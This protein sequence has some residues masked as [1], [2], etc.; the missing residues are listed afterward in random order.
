M[1]IYFKSFS[2][3]YK[4]YTK[5]QKERLILVSTQYLLKAGIV[6]QLTGRQL[7]TL[8]MN[9]SNEVYFVAGSNFELLLLA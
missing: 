5:N 6:V 7:P 1:E 8:H 9:I 4:L 2:I 3:N